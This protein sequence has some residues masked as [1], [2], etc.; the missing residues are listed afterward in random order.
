VEQELLTL[1]KHSSSPPVF[2]EVRVTRS[3]YLYVCFVDR[4]LS[5]CPFSFDHGVVCSSSIYKDSD[6]S[7]DI[8][9]L[10]LLPKISCN[11][12]CRTK[13]CKTCNILTTDA[14]FTSNFTNKNYFTRSYD[15]VNRKSANMVYG[16]ECNLYG[17]GYI[18]K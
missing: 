6:Y 17:L 2:S 16:L 5:F 4:C 3:L 13:N 7:F 9:K 10:F 8:F 1:P 18:G 14:H 12:L 15:D 11:Q